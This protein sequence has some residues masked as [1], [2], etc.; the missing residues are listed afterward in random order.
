[1]VHRDQTGRTDLSDEAKDRLVED[2]LIKFSSLLEQREELPC[3]ALRQEEEVVQHPLA[4]ALQRLLGDPDIILMLEYQIESWCNRD[5]KMGALWAIYKLKD[6]AS[7][8]RDPQYVCELEDRLE[9]LTPGLQGRNAAS[10]RT[11]L[12]ALL[13]ELA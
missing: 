1:M 12:M 8:L 9:H 7:F 2:L 4:Q 3:D 5:A 13:E 11:A 6:H 10:F